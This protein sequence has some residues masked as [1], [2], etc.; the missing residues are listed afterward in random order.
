[1]SIGLFCTVALLVVLVLGGVAV[2]ALQVMF[3]PARAVVGP[4]ALSDVPGMSPTPG[5]IAVQEL[6]FPTFEPFGPRALLRS[7]ESLGFQPSGA[8][9]VQNPPVPDVYVA[10]L[11]RPD[12][13]ARVW[14][15][16]D[17]TPGTATVCSATQG[18]RVV[19]SGTAEATSLHDKE[20]VEAVPDASPIALVQR[21]EERMAGRTPLEHA[22]DGAVQRYMEEWKDD[23]A[24][25]KRRSLVARV[26]GWF[27]SKRSEA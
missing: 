12:A 9:V 1:M 3:S 16:P 7:F 22:V 19:T 8:V 2:L 17:G 25:M 21:H 26:A 24:A 13:D 4:C 14:I 18:V 11:T 5:Q 10:L 23:L 27:G 6:G 20:D 15:Q